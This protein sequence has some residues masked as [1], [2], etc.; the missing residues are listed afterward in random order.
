MAAERDTS[1]R[2]AAPRAASWRPLGVFW[3]VLLVIILAGG[4]TLQMLG[5]PV[6]HPVPAP[7]LAQEKPEAPPRPMVASAARTIGTPIDAPTLDFEEP[8]PHISGLSL[9]RITADGRKPMDA[10]AAGFDRADRSPR[11][12]LML[13]GIGLSEARDD[14]A[15]RLAPALSFALSPYSGRPGR[16]VEMA[17]RAGHEIWLGIPMEPQGYPLNDPGPLAM[18]TSQA[19]ELNAERLERV[20]GLVGGYVGLTNAIGNM[21]GERFSATEGMRTVLNEARARGLMFLDARPNVTMTVLPNL[22]GRAIDLVV[23]QQAGAH[24]IELQ[25]DRLTSLAKAQGTAIGFVG[26]PTPVALERLAVWANLLAR[27]G[28]VLVPVSALVAQRETQ[29]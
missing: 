12:A 4:T 23:D 1:E 10:F 24:E 16:I 7:L 25:L 3:G 27:Q 13:A 20:M 28:A 5:A 8:A 2:K 26:S 19:P 22:V 6:E 21:R 9:P 17:H 14:E 15:V 18:L 11:V 29:K